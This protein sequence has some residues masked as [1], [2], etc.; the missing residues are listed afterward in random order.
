MQVM[1]AKAARPAGLWLN[2][3][4]ASNV[5]HCE[6]VGSFIVHRF[7]NTFITSAYYCFASC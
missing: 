5:G 3:L 7:K 2:E 4:R 1:A 6:R